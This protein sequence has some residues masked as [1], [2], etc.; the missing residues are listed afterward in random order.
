M[1]VCVYKNYIYIYIYI[2]IKRSDQSLRKGRKG[3]K[4]ENVY[5]H[6]ISSHQ[7]FSEFDSGVRPSPKHG[8]QGE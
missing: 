7:D 1:C 2:G 4:G 8:R 3:K 5:I 6:F